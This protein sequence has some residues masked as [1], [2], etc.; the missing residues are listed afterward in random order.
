MQIASVFLPKIEKRE[1]YDSQLYKKV[2]NA[3]KSQ[4][5]GQ[6][7]SPKG[8]LIRIVKKEGKTF[9]RRANNNPI[10]IIAEGKNTYHVA[11][12]PKEKIVFYKD[13]IIVFYPTGKNDIYKRNKQLHASLSDLE[14]F[15]GTYVS[16]ELD[17]SFKLRLSEK[18]TLKVSSSNRKGEL[19]VEVLNRNELLA[20]NF[21]MKVQRDVFDRPTDILVSLG[22]AKNNRFKKKTNLIFQPKIDAENGTI[23][24]TTIGS[25]NNDASNILLTKNFDNGNEIWSQQ[26]GGNSYDK[27]SSILATENGYLIIGSTSSY[28]KGNYDMFV[29][30]TDKKGTK[31]WQNTYGN[32]YNEYG[33]SAEKTDSGYLIKGTIQKCSS[34]TDVFNRKCKTNVWFVSIDKKGKE[35]STKVLE[36]VK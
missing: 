3:K 10:E 14:S 11:Y 17:M 25:R 34:N 22:R 24:V 18:N 6:Y 36:E 20:S 7:I 15:V 33:Y 28:G 31:I 23:Q 1:K 16:N 8:A 5:K 13:E 21:I 4:I 29:I 9:W 19:D 26:F 32:F 27:A 35:L 2:S 12:D 30:K